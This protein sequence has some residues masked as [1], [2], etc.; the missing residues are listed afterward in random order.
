MK[1]NNLAKVIFDLIMLL[2]LATV[3]CARSSGILIHEYI[4]LLV[5]IFFIFHLAYNHK[6]ITNVSKKLFNRT[7]GKRIKFMYVINCLLLVDFILIGLSGI[8]ISRE[9]FSFGGSP[10][11]RLMHTVVSAISIILL[12]IHIGLH[13][14]MILNTV[15][16]ISLPFITIKIISAAILLI[17]FAAGI[18]GDIIMKME[19]SQGQMTRR[20]RYETAIGLFQRSVFLL[21]SFDQIRNLDRMNRFSGMDRS[22][23]IGR[24]GGMDRP[25]G[26][27][28][29][30]GMDRPEGMGRP[31]GMNGPGGR[32]NMEM[33]RRM[34]GDGNNPERNLGSDGPRRGFH[35]MRSGDIEMQSNFSIKM[36]LISV[37][38]YVAF[39]ML[40]SIIVFII[41]NRIM[42][43]KRLLPVA[44]AT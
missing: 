24:P 30:G 3:Y 28:R 39:I 17:I 43:R 26:M 4:G 1:L 41:D 21:S 34:M 11:W 7:V 2:L 19:S 14:K 8:M 40:C 42:K 16:K 10:F 38:N 20:P 27:G 13:G 23:G 18:Y 33:N 32:E 6:W 35:E 31:G 15:K 29:P 9:I 37:P 12:G 25:E 5:F 44:E 22:E 36:L